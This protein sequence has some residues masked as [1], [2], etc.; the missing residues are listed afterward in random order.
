ME[1]LSN[2]ILRKVQFYDTQTLSRAYGDAI[3][4][5]VK[6][7]WV[8]K[9]PLFIFYIVIN[10]QNFDKNAWQKAI[11]VVVNINI[12]IIIIIIIVY[13]AVLLLFYLNFVV[14]AIVGKVKEIKMMGASISSYNTPNKNQ[15]GRKKILAKNIFS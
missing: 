2:K 6:R 15:K 4:F 12:I 3:Y 9:S 11:K 14:V 7:V 1:A 10:L 8:K 5:V 13:V